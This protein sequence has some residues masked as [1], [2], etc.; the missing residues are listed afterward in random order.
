MYR[1]IKILLTIATHAHGNALLEAAILAAI[2]I[3]TQ[4]AALLVLGA[5]SVLDLL[6]YGAAEEAL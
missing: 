5:G 1:A 2:A 4:N 6:L 3:D